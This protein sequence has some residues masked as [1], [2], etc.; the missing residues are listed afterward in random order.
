MLLKKLLLLS[1]IF[2]LLFLSLSYFS[3]LPS[4]LPSL[5]PS[6]LSFFPF[7]AY[8]LP[9]FPPS[10]HTDTMILGSKL[11]E[12]INSSGRSVCPSRQYQNWGQSISFLDSGFIPLGAQLYEG[13][14]LMRLLSLGRP[15]F[16]L[17]F[18]IKAETQGLQVSDE[19]LRQGQL[20][21]LQFLLI[22][23]I[24]PSVPTQQCGT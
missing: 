18:H 4:F 20:C 10:F 24:P 9:L 15:K 21:F 23:Q 16:Y 6:F 3:F 22:S 13:K 12:V 2:K 5:L 1:Y 11:S 8:L 7:H 14:R 17:L 19:I